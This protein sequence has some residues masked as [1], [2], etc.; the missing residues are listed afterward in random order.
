MT[1]E[2]PAEEIVMP[3]DTHATEQEPAEAT[4]ETPPEAFE[5]PPEFLPRVDDLITED[6]T[7]V[8][9]I[10]SAKQQRLLV[11][12][13]YSSWQGGT[14][15]RLFIADANV[16]LFAADHQLPLVPD[17]FLSMDVKLPQNLWLKKHRSYFFWL[18]GKPPEVVI[19]V[20]SNKKGG[21]LDSKLEDYAW[22]RIF[23]YVVFDPEEQLGS[24][25]LRIFA[26]NPGG[27]QEITSFW[28][29]E[30]GVGLTLW[31]G[32]YE[33]I[34][35]VWLRWCDAEGNVIPTGG[36]RARQEAA[37]RQA[38]EEQARQEAA[39]RQ[40]AQE[41]ARQ[42]AAARRAAQA[43]ARQDAAARQA[44]EE[45]VRQEAAARQAAEAQLS[46]AEAELARLRAE[47]ERLRGAADNA[48]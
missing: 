3:P 15:Q 41:Q 19:E 4:V 40:E 11:E 43:Q 16:G 14:A 27:Y 24:G 21:E 37:A 10:F 33:T 9:N 8:D 44:A 39:A 48:T 46:T 29:P 31:Q 32:E 45:Q 5:I 18:Y 13:L 2:T 28:L 34:N 7:P 38:A 12:P 35:A 42:E 6:D 22:M 26:L 17:G 23:Y 30:L 36:E 47:L 20:V 25:K 1:V